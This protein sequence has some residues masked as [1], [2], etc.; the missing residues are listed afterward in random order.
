MDVYSNRYLTKDI[1]FSEGSVNIQE[2]QRFS[3]KVQDVIITKDSET[4]DD[5]GVPTVLL[6][7]INNLICGYH[8]CILRTKDLNLLMGEFLMFQLQISLVNKQFANKANG[9][10]RYGLTLGAIESIY[11]K[12]PKNISEQNEIS[13]RLRTIDN[14][15]QSEQSY[16]HKMQK[17][18]AGLMGDLLTGKKKVKLKEKK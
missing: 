1:S 15:L 14:K 4:P 7:K 10:T 5:I 3:L 12:I 8:L 13:K 2:M 9:S 6:H 17:I 11:L 16:L 18:K